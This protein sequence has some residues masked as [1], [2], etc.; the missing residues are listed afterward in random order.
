MQ[1][2]NKNLMSTLG[3]SFVSLESPAIMG[4]INCT[5]DSFHDQSRW[6]NQTFETLTQWIEAGVD[7]IDIGGQST[8]PG[9]ER[10]NENEEWLRVKPVLEWLHQ[11]APQ[12]ALS[13]D[14]YF[15]SVAQNAIHHGAHIVND[16]SAGSMDEGLIPWIIQEKI[17]YVL[18]HMQGT[19][20]T[21]QDQ[22][23]YEN[24]TEEIL[25]FF[26][27]KLKH[28]P[29]DHPVIIDPGFGFGKT[30][31]HN[32]TLLRELEKFQILDKPILA[33]MSR[34]KMIQTATALNAGD[35]GPGSLVAHTLACINGA[36]I[37]RTHDVLESI[38]MK[39]I[40]QH[41]F[42]AK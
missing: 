29:S 28:F 13:I 12:V 11:N 15:L 25:S 39:K 3:H 21:M 41:T 18:M 2:R 16:V 26:Q 38:Q 10:I 6:T 22:P 5:P 1:K 14:T 42:P 40:I 37:I 7:I 33:G 27:E 32:F 31:E 34:K 30:L 4:V 23:R 20:A 36:S 8:R 19:L 9:S 35:C 17:P 24:V